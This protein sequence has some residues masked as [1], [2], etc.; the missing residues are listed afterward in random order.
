LL[1]YNYLSLD[2]VTH[3]FLIYLTRFTS[4]STNFHT[5]TAGCCNGKHN[6]SH[7]CTLKFDIHANHHNTDLVYG[8]HGSN[9][10]CQE[11]PICLQAFLPGDDVAWSLRQTSCRNVFHMMCIEAWL[12]TSTDLNCPC[13]RG[14]YYHVFTGE[15]S[16]VESGKEIKLLPCIE[17]RRHGYFCVTHGLFLP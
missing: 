15:D 16:L 10:A 7:K 8:S 1:I 5:V 17:T 3:R 14:N 12:E 13:C 9:D 4:Y 2:S 11:C 6:E